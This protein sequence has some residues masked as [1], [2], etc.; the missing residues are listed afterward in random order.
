MYEGLIQKYNQ[1]RNIGARESD[2]LRISSIYGSSR[3]SFPQIKLM[4]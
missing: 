2:Q 4:K 3:L 1:I